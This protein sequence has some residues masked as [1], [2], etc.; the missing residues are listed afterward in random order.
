MLALRDRPV[1][2]AC[3]IVAGGAGAGYVGAWRADGE[4]EKTLYQASTGLIFVALLG[5]AVKLLLDDVQRIRDERREQA[6]F[7][8]QMLDDLKAVY[9]RVERA[10]IL[11]RAHRSALTYGTEMRALIDSAV[12]LRNITRALDYTSGVLEA[13]GDVD[14]AV[15]RME[16][17]VDGLTGEFQKHYK[18]IADKQNVYEARAGKARETEAEAPPNEAWEDLKLLPCLGEF[19]GAAQHAREAELSYKD[20]FLGSLDRGSEALRAELL[21]IT[22]GRRP[23]GRAR[24][25]HAS[26]T[27]SRAPVGPDAGPG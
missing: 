17:Y 23:S 8:R 20:D 10:R 18:P 1:V 2:I 24:S 12:A 15:R 13:R 14:Q 9:D 26:Q 3:L 22:Q 27:S 4:L 25:V 16:E 11:I 5:G 19:R 21:R 6:R 7:V